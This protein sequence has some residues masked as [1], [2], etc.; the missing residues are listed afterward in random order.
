MDSLENGATI[1]TCSS[2]NLSNPLQVEGDGI[3]DIEVF[4]HRVDSRIYD[5]ECEIRTLKTRRNAATFTCRLPAEL[6]SRIFLALSHMSSQN[7]TDPV[8]KRVDWL[9]CTFVCRRW[10]DVALSCTELWTTPVFAVPA[11]AETMLARSKDAPLRIK[12]SGEAEQPSETLF[13][14]LSQLDRLLS[15]ELVDSEVTTGSSQIQEMLSSWTGQAPLLTTLHLH[16]ATTHAT[17]HTLPIDFLQGGTPSLK[18]VVLGMWGNTW[19]NLPLGPTITCL[20]IAASSTNPRRATQSAFLSCIKRL[21]FLEVLTLNQ[22]LPSRE[23]AVVS[24][25]DRRLHLPRLRT[26]SLGDSLLNMDVFFRLL[27]VPDEVNVAL[28]C[29]GNIS[30]LEETLKSAKTF[31]TKGD[32]NVTKGPQTSVRYLVIY[33][34]S[35][36]MRVDLWWKDSRLTSSTV[37]PDLSLNF[38][39]NFHSP[40]QPL[41]RLLSHFV[42]E[43]LH[44]I[45]VNSFRGMDKN[46]WRTL[47]GRLPYVE[48]V[49]VDRGPLHEWL[50]ILRYDPPTESQGNRTENGERHF[51]GLIHMGFRAMDLGNEKAETLRLL[52]QVLKERSTTSP[53]FKMDVIFGKCPDPNNNYEKMKQATEGL[54]VNWSFF[55]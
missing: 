51:P 12:F 31:A 28:H 48:T 15:V 50:E 55:P 11:L 20:V 3:D 47:L 36:R 44:T 52:V 45:H 43:S 32:G 17:T 24:P 16:N 29:I 4:H 9:I 25:P 38:Y 39:G 35:T 53:S 8:H 26:L 10:R 27:H 42:L 1:T 46:Q 2:S 18:T 13:T 37:T 14:S 6:L 54:N 49:I 5:L 41:F 30:M 22:M 7:I 40:N 19:E 23:S 33:T 34:D 21:P